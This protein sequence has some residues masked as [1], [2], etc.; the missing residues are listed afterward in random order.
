MTEK[1]IVVIEPDGTDIYL[2]GIPNEIRQFN[3]AAG[4]VLR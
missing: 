2:Y 1:R 4:K 3:A